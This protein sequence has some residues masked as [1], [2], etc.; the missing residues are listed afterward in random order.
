MSPLRVHYDAETHSLPVRLGLLNSRGTQDLLIH[1]LAPH[2]Q[3]YEVANYAN[4]FVPTNLRVTDAVRENFG[5]FYETVFS[6]VARRGTVVTEY[7]WDAGSCDPCPTPPLDDAEIA[8]LGGSTP[9]SS[10]TAA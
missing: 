3:R 4:A 2:R 8:T 7:A 1:V 5:G 9:P 10:G 6:E